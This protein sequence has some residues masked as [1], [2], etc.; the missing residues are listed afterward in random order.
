M[1]KHPA[2]RLVV[3][4]GQEGQSQAGIPAAGMAGGKMKQEGGRW[5][6]RFVCSGFRGHSWDLGHEHPPR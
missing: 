4:S 3:S 5:D 6:Q 1:G 2:R